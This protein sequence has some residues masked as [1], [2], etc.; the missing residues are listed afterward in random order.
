MMNKNPH[1]DD[2]NVLPTFQ[3][4]SCSI[5]N[6]QRDT[7]KNNEYMNQDD[8]QDY[9]EEENNNMGGE[10][11]DDFEDLLGQR[12]NSL[13]NIVYASRN[14]ETEGYLDQSMDKIEEREENNEGYEDYDI[15]PNENDCGSSNR[16]PECR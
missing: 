15:E 14:T 6:T 12:Q 2:N 1:S 11:N 3:S 8:E 16:S 7:F 9:Y 5:Q 4:T 10:G 13:E